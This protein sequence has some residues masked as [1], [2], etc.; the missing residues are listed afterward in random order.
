MRGGGFVELIIP[1]VQYAQLL[2]KLCSRSQ[3]YKQWMACPRGFMTLPDPKV[4]SSFRLEMISATPSLLLIIF[5]FQIP[6]TRL[7]LLHLFSSFPRPTASHETEPESASSYCSHS[8]APIPLQHSAACQKPVLR[9]LPLMNLNRMTDSEPW[10]YTA[11]TFP[12]G[13]S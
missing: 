6:T 12:I 2:P 9:E 11:F 1:V 3:V 4:A 5:I 7:H 8:S 13:H 10:F